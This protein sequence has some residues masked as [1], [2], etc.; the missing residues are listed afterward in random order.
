MRLYNL[1]MSNAKVPTSRRGLTG[2]LLQTLSD[3]LLRCGPFYSAHALN[4][5]FIDRRLYPWRYRV[6]DADTPQSRVQAL[7][8]YLHDQTT[9]DGDNALA[10]FVQVLRDQ[11]DVGDACYRE[12][13]QL[14]IALSG[15]SATSLTPSGAMP[16]STVTAGDPYTPYETAMRVLLSRLGKTHPRYNEALIYQQRLDE[17]LKGTRLYGDTETR[18]AERAEILARLNALS[19]ATLDT[20]FSE[21]GNASIPSVAP[22]APPGSIT[23]IGDGNV[24]GNNNQV[25]INK[26]ATA[27]PPPATP[28]GLP[29]RAQALRLLTLLTQHFSLDELNTLCFAVG[30]NFDELPGAGLTGKARELLSY[31][32]R[33]ACMP[34]LINAGQTL[35]P[36]LDWS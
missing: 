5:V 33:H 34:A 23:V 8:A 21:L 18:R 10:L 27:N 28:S 12:L 2:D 3:T 4:A 13:D 30:V 1:S 20:L 29:D 19:M 11:T 16:P 32:E 25:S 26:P 36:E 7:I 14:A 17:N 22:S 15:G 24:V 9:V 6:P 35:R 31:C